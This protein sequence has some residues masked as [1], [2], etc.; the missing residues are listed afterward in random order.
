M[1]ISVVQKTPNSATLAGGNNSG[2]LASAFPS[3]V[4]AGNC[5]IVMGSSSRGSAPSISDNRG[6]T[7]VSVGW[8]NK[9]AGGATWDAWYCASAI[10]G[11]TTI[12]LS[13]TGTGDT[14]LGAVEVSGLCKR[15]PL[16]S[17]N[18]TTTSGLTSPSI[19]TISASSIVFGFAFA[20]NGSAAP[21]VGNIDGS[22]ATAIGV[23]N[24]GG[25]NPGW[26]YRILSSTATTTAAFATGGGTMYTQIAVFR[27]EMLAPAHVQDQIGYTSGSGATVVSASGTFMPGSLIVV[28]VGWLNASA[29]TVSSIA[30]SSG[31]NTW[32]QVHAP[33]AYGGY[34]ASDVWYAYNAT[35]FTGTI[36]VTLSSS[37]ATYK[38][39]VVSEYTGFT[40]PADPLDTH[41]DAGEWAT[42]VN[43]GAT[44]NITTW[45]GPGV[46]IGFVKFAASPTV[47]ARTINGGAVDGYV[48]VT[49]GELTYK[50][51]TGTMTGEASWTVNSASDSTVWIVSFKSHPRFTA[52]DTLSLASDL[53]VTGTTP[54]GMEYVQSKGLASAGSSGTIAQTLD[55]DVLSGSL[56]VVVASCVD[57]SG[58]IT[59]TCA[60]SLG[61]SYT[62]GVGPTRNADLNGTGY[63]QWIFYKASSPSGANTVTVTFSTST[64][65]RRI[66]IL[67]YSGVALSS[68]VTGTPVGATGT[69]GAPNSGNTTTTVDDALIV[70]GGLHDGGNLTAG[71][72]FT[73][74]VRAD[75]Y[76]C[77][78]D[79]IVSSAGAYA[80]TFSTGTSD[81]IAQVIAFRSSLTGVYFSVTETLSA[82]FTL[83]T[84]KVGSNLFSSG[85]ALALADSLTVNANS[86]I[87]QVSVLESLTVGEIGY[88]SGDTIT[89]LPSDGLLLDDSFT[90]FIDGRSVET[91]E[92][93]SL[94]DS[95]TIAFNQS[96]L[97][98][99]ESADFADSVAI[100][101]SGIK[102]SVY[103]DAVLGDALTVL[104][105]VLTFEGLDS[106][107]LSDSMQKASGT[108]TL[109]FTET[110]SLADSDT[111]SPSGAVRFSVTDIASF[112]DAV[113][114]ATTKQVNTLYCF[115]SLTGSSASLDSLDGD[116]LTDGDRAWVIASNVSYWY[117]L[118]ED[119]GATESSPSI[120]AP[121]TNA[122]AKRWRRCT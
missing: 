96:G 70:G 68:P 79:K 73:Q 92:S 51:M 36:T 33:R 113:Q 11:A 31:S 101:P 76:D 102:F 63:A 90:L 56:L 105:P 59:A 9:S 53:E 89:V 28:C 88:L 117:Y 93:L 71:A 97:S 107:A 43:T 26:E 57:A 50:V 7:Y 39:L 81:W 27:P 112:T 45:N 40:S 74:R 13:A 55:S 98:F 77:T 67:E 44:G 32:V 115:S 85:D 35:G 65:D 6:N 100:K 41:Q 15:Y 121:N 25:D 69:T 116:A 108:I 104:R 38:S 18:S 86:Q 22:A 10:G 8:A 120:I 20:G 91:A 29:A 83:S 48:A 34:N 87:V 75:G 99:S 64:T 122:G 12:T 58:T 2:D 23:T 72:T 78:E 61:S 95:A 62:L 84:P 103:H 24:N 30:Q 110:L 42:T 5:I 37:S 106:I 47:S 114:R 82:A 118:D 54:P 21:T 1:A 119:S 17:H 94:A 49:Q 14:Y 111:V 3:N 52:T 4:T 109:S 16:D 19:T 80:A 46:V 66:D 60:D